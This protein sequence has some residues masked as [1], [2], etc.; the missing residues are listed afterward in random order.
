MLLIS[1]I[2]DEIQFVSYNIE[3]NKTK[4]KK[5]INTFIYFRNEMLKRNKS[6]KIRIK[7]S[8]F[9]KKMMEKWRELPEE[10]KDE[11]RRKRDLSQNASAPKIQQEVDEINFYPCEICGYTTMVPLICNSCQLYGFDNYFYYLY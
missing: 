3:K 9:S 2:M 6:N 5:T 11:W 8:E 7:M 10:E 1:I 4:S